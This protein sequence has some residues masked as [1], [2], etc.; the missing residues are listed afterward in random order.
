MT[1]ETQSTRNPVFNPEEGDILSLGDKYVLVD[2]CCPFA[3]VPFAVGFTRSDGT[4][5]GFNYRASWSDFARNFKI[6][7]LGSPDKWPWVYEGSDREEKKKCSPTREESLQYLQDRLKELR[8]PNKIV[9]KVEEDMD[10]SQILCTTYQMRNFYRQ[11]ADGLFSNLD[12]MNYMQHQHILKYM[13]KGSKVLD[14]CCGRSL[15]LPLMRW[16]KKNIHSYTGVDISEKNIREA[17]RWS[18]IKKVEDKEGY[19]PFP[20]NYVLANVA[21]MAKHLSEDV[22]FDVIIYTSSIEHMQ[23]EAGAQ[24]LREC[25]KLLTSGGTLFISCPNTV[26]KKDPYDTQYAAHLYEWDVKELTKELDEVG[27]EIKEK[28]GLVMKK[29]KLDKFFEGQDRD[30]GGV[31]WSLVYQVMKNYMPTAWL[32]AVMAIPFPHAADEVALVCTKK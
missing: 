2:W 17:K 25:Y 8:E 20:V 5:G 28:F 9:L 26:E 11:M 27:F 3:V 18:G 19:Y 29:R 7:E 13:R 4:Q 22:Q 10:P 15:M 14:V 6:V 23:R 31:N 21:E 12:I 24:S 32:C 1:T 30:G 16:H